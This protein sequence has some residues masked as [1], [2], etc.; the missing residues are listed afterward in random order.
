MRGVTDLSFFD[1]PLFS[2]FYSRFKL[3]ERGVFDISDIPELQES[4][5]ER[6]RQDIAEIEAFNDYK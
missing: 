2:Y 4:E 6:S 3:H 1:I 5:T